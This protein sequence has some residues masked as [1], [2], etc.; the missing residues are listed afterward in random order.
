[1]QRTAAATAALL[2]LASLTSGCRDWELTGESVE[3]SSIEGWYE[4]ELDGWGEPTVTRSVLSDDYTFIEVRQRDATGEVTVRIQHDGPVL[5]WTD[6]VTVDGEQVAPPLPQVE[7]ERVID[8]ER[9][10]TGAPIVEVILLSVEDEEPAYEATRRNDRYTYLV[11]AEW[12]EEQDRVEVEIVLQ[13]D[14]RRDP[15][16][17]DDDDDDDWDYYYDC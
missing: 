12:P 4:T 11:V 9:I 2:A 16:P 14:F 15:P 7:V 6:P 17:S 3:V 10:V 5:G 1:M 8:G 13:R